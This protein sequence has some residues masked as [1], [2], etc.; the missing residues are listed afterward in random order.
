[1]NPGIIG[2]IASS[3]NRRNKNRHYYNDS[4]DE[5]KGCCL[6]VLILMVIFIAIAFISCNKLK[7]GEVIEKWYEPERTYVSLMPMYIGNGKT[8]TVIF[9]PY[10]ITD[11]EDYVIKIKGKYKGKDRVE[12]VYVNPK[13]YECLRTGDH[14]TIGKDCSLTDDNNTKV[15]K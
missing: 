3:V 9:I 15:E 14:F 7:E 6:I 1:M 12:T 13:E 11:N 5:E 8:F 4:D 2:A 10:I